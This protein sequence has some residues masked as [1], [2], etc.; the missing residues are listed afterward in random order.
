MSLIESKFMLL[1]QMKGWEKG[2]NIYSIKRDMFRSAP[3]LYK[4]I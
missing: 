3:N 1:V 2:I 4:I